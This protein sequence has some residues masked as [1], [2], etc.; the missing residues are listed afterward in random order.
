MNEHN[1]PEGV[2]GPGPHE[3]PETAAVAVR[4]ERVDVVRGDRMDGVLSWIGWH[5]G[6]LAAVGVPAVLA[7]TTHPLWTVPAVVVAAGWVAHEVRLARRLVGGADIPPANTNR[8]NLTDGTPTPRPDETV[9][10]L[11]AGP[12]T[13]PVSGEEGHRGLA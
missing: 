9:S 12:G 10:P 5:L 13:G 8:A 4:T 7:V 1:S 3:T 2:P 11:S 6:E